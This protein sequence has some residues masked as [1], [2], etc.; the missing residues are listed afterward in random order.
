MP[1]TEQAHAPDTATDAARNPFH[2]P[3]WIV[4]TVVVA[5]IAAM[6]GWLLLQPP[7]EHRQP[8]PAPHQRQQ[9]APA[10]PVDARS[11]CGLQPGEQT[12]PAVRPAP[13]DGFTWTLVGTMAAPADPVHGPGATRDVTVPAAISGEDQD[14]TV[15]LP[16]C[17]SPDPWGAI[18]AAYNFVAVTSAPQLRYAA[19]QQ[20][21]L[22]GPG[23]DAALAGMRASGV[24]GQTSGV[25]IVGFT[26]TGYVPAT[27][28]TLD[29]ALT[30]G[31]GGYAH[32]PLSLVWTRGDWLVQ[33]PVTGSP[34]DTAQPLPTPAGYVPFQGA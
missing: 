28:A 8:G 30:T 18:Y 11:V 32:F 27:S 34:F 25:Q 12:P 29:L 21:T 5:I 2:K 13:G 1:D 14:T 19:A 10:Q 33:L 3:W 4:S 26:V 24:G 23:Q 31:H 6:L 16:V 20:L 15:Y 22:P 9:Q 7:A 17:Y